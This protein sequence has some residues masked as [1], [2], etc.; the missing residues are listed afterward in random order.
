MDPHPDYTD[1]DLPRSFAL[2]AYRMAPLS[3]EHVQED[4]DA[5][6]A[7]APL[8]DGIF[9]DWPAGLTLAD[10][11]VDLSWHE[12]EFT[13]RRSFAWIIRDAEG[14][15]L[16]CFYIYPAIGARGTAEA[17]LWLCDMPDRRTVAQTLKTDLA[18]WMATALPAGITFDWITR[19][20]LDAP[21]D[22]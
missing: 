13:A 16:G 7:T 17:I 3:P 22:A 10:N 6:H 5:V 8:F 9:G 21:A 15:Y 4:F 19:P 18:A 1:T 14:L 2:G 20:V 11:L 12:R